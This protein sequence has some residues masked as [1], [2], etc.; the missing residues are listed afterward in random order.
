M[1]IPYPVGEPLTCGQ[2]RELDI[3]AIEHVGIPGVVLME[4][5]GRAVAGILYDKLLNPAAARVV[6]LCGAGNNG[7]DGL[8]VA[9][10]LRDARVSVSVVLA[11]P[12]D[13]VHGDAALNLGIYRRLGGA[14]IDSPGPQP[15]PAALQAIEQADVVVDALLGTGAR[16]APRGVL[17]GLIRAANAA[18]A[19]RVAIDLPT[20]LDGDTGAVADPCFQAHL[21]VTLVAEKVGFTAAAAR[22]M[23]GALHVVEIGV[24]REM[25][26]GRKSM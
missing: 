4:N 9:R 22:Q 13:S 20:G 21:T 17:A 11:A 5:A 1:P 15:A 25:I 12:P 26:P 23:L 18:R 3:L 24:P 6:V 16:G 10:C 7:G 2:L 14:M 19:W 8:V